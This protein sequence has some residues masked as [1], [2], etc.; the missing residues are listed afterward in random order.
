MSDSQS[1]QEQIQSLFGKIIRARIEDNRVIEGEFMC[2]DREM[3][4]IVGGATEYH[5]VNDIDFT[6]TPE[7]SRRI[8][9]A[10]IPGKNIT[11]ICVQNV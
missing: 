2:I 5:N 7:I 4:I 3:N 11:A 8:G 6:T 10:M 9:M 1:S